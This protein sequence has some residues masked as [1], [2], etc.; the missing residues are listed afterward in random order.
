MGALAAFLANVFG[1]FLGWFLKKVTIRG[2]KVLAYTTAYVALLLALFLAA[3]ALVAGFVFI[4]PPGALLTGF[5]LLWPDNA[6]MVFAAVMGTDLSVMIFRI[7]RDNM[8]ALLY[9]T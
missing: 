2:A 7:H 1:G 6:E 3:K 8:R 9:V 5:Y 4:A